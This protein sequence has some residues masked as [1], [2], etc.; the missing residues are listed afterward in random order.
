VREGGV[1][2]GGEMLYR[3][4]TWLFTGP[5]KEK[6][7]NVRLLNEA[8]QELSE[9]ISKLADELQELRSEHRKLRGRFYAARGELQPDEP[10]SRDARKAQALRALGFVPGRAAPHQSHQP[11]DE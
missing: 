10:Q 9:Q 6:P 11:R 1:L 7:T 2:G 5:P 8:K 4:F 3:I